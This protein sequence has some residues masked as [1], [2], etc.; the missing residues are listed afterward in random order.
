MFTDRLIDEFLGKV[1]AEGHTAL[2]SQAH[3]NELQNRK[4]SF[5]VYGEGHCL[6]SASGR[7]AADG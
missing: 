6:L 7:H 4:M 2:C 5:S 1:K 3:S